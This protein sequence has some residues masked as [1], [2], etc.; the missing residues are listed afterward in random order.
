L[1]SFYNGTAFLLSADENKR[2]EAN[3]ATPMFLELAI[4][5]PVAKALSLLP[6]H[7]RWKSTTGSGNFSEAPQEHR[8]VDFLCLPLF[9]AYIPHCL[10]FPG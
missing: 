8:V 6:L 4:V 2:V 1:Q 7:R 3:G 5:L 10:M 9:S